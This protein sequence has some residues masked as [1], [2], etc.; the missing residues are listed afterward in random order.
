MFNRQAISFYL[1][2]PFI[3][4]IASLP[5]W[6]LYKVSDFFYFLLNLSGYRKTVV[7]ENLR[8][9]FPQK[10]E[11]EIQSIRRSFFRYLVDL[12]FETLKTLR[13]DRMESAAHCTLENPAWLQKLHEEKRSILIVMGHYGNWEWA[14]P[15]VT[16]NTKYQLVVIY[17]PLSNAYFEKM[18]V[19]M[20]TRFGT[21]ITPVQQTLRGM[22]AQRNMI[23]ATAFIADQYPP[24]EGK[25][26]TTFLNQ[27]TG[28]FT[29]P[30]KL[31][32]KF[33]YPIVYIHINRKSRGQYHI[34]PELLFENPQE[35]KEGEITLAFAKRLEKDIIE[36]PETWLW[37]HKRWKHKR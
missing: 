24:A 25:I 21:L 11:E 14:G 10:S 31:A 20:R 3:Y 15:S 7:I 22:V 36:N 9:S 27:D 12:I 5:F 2:Y 8:N 18:M 34:T 1:V 6:M 16:I 35:T 19:G 32:T 23:T 33:N 37:S 13:M 29:G 17:R 26:W 28:F 30:E 4:L